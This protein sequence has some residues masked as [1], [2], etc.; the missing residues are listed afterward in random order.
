MLDLLEGADDID[1]AAFGKL[2]P[3]IVENLARLAL[4]RGGCSQ[5]EDSRDTLGS[6][7]AESGSFPRRMSALRDSASV[8]IM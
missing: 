3:E 7:S 2:R 5:G 4:R 8:G 6:R 1:Y